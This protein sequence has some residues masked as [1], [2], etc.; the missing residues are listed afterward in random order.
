VR[1]IVLLGGN[2]QVGWELQRALAPLAEVI[3]LGREG[4]TYPCR[5][6]DRLLCGDLLRPDEV[7]ATVRQLAPDCVVNAAAYT[8]VDRAE[9]EQELAMSIN[10]IAPGR[11]AAACVELGIWLVHY[12]TDHVFDGSGDQ[13]WCESDPT[14]PLNAYGRTKL[15][16]EDL[17]RSSG[18]R[19]LILRASWVY[20]AR[21]TNF[22]KSILRLASE[23]DSVSVVADQ[24]GAPTSAVLLADVT[25]HALRAVENGT[26]RGGTFHVA[27]AGEVSRH[28][29]ARFVV[30]C[31]R[32]RGWRLTVEPHG[33]V[34]VS[35][36]AF[37][38]RA[39]RPRNSR[40]D[41]RRL[42]GAF[43]LRMPPWQHGVE[44]LVDEL[45][46]QELVSGRTAAR[47]NGSG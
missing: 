8:A 47:V 43:G 35:S 25:A 15:E 12:S 3:V 40:L 9:Q 17:I 19:H 41:C 26:D 33:I 45:S 34:P 13:A 36:E 30:D 7:V 11:L 29:Y 16:G 1:R 37:P 42:E 10:V 2:G 46:G 18:C 27:A 5:R 22:P 44:R 31:A 21:G 24:V 32:A 28:D 6:G 39:K 38:T 23:R 14:G 20:A 4:T